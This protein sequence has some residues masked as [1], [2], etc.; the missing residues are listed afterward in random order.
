M[1]QSRRVRRVFEEAPLPVSPGAS[2]KSR[3]TLRLR[4]PGLVGLVYHGNQLVPLGIRKYTAAA[5][6][7]MTATI[8]THL[9]QSR[10]IGRRRGPPR[11]MSGAA[12]AGGRAPLATGTATT[13]ALRRLGPDAASAAS[14]VGRLPGT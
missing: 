4:P 9:S 11:S 7:A 2:S 5:A 13:A 3:R 8:S 10:E 14:G 12:V 6:A 1:R